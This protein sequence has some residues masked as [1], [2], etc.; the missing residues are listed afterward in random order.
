MSATA[1]WLLVEYACAIIFASER[2]RNCIRITKHHQNRQNLDYALLPPQKNW[3]KCC[4]NQ[5][6]PVVAEQKSTQK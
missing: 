6:D 1:V 4:K 3:Q 2:H 5:A